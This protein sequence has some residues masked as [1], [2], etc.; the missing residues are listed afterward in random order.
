MVHVIPL[1][2]AQRRRDP[3]KT[4]QAPEI[5]PIA[6]P[7]RGYAG[8]V[9][10]LT[11]HYQQRMA[12]QEAFDTDFIRRHFDG[13]L[14]KA[15]DEAAAKAPADGRGLHDAIYGELDPYTGQVAKPGLF[16]AL[17][18]DILRQVPEGQRADFIRQG[19][20]T[21]EARSLRLAARQIQ[22]R[23]AYEQ[24]RL[25][26]VLNDNAAAIGKGGGADRQGSTAGAGY[27]D[28]RSDYRRCRRRCRRRRG[29]GL[30][31]RAEQPE[32]GER[33]PCRE[34]DAG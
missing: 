9:G 11:A 1:S 22:L 4:Q 5:T 10:E 15:E 12:Q 2:I 30:D 34:T 14:A 6:G 7:T 28:D 16:D 29:H 21:R 19:S 33:R 24:A 27:A 23:D 17:F 13:Q 20:A 8:D 31:A 3:D 18:Q 32:G 26:T 25:D